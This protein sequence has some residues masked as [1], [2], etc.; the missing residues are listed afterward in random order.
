MKAFKKG[1]K[2]YSIAHLKC[3]KCHEGDLFATKT[4]SFSKPFD[5]HKRCPKCAFKMEIEPGFF[6]G[7]MLISYTLIVCFCLFFVT[8]CMHYF[9]W[10]VDLS[11]IA[12]VIALIPL[13]VGIFRFSRLIWLNFYVQYDPDAI[14]VKSN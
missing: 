11:F 12:L 6:Y 10:S 4:L 2:L 3:P 1:S 7:A 8:A 9:G 13:Y 14:A 5:M